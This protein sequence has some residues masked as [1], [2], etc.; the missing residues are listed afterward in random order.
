[1]YVLGKRLQTGST[2]SISA[3]QQRRTDG[4]R[5][6]R[7]TTETG[8]CDYNGRSWK[9]RRNKKGG[10]IVAY[11]LTET[12]A[13]DYT[14]RSWMGRHNEK[15]ETAAAQQQ[16]SNSSTS[17]AAAAAAA[18]EEE[19]AAAAAVVAVAAQAA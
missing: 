7:E 13:C 9:G 5:H 1:M 11:F 3:L 17:A 18:A 14:G 10:K 6:T 4:R 12:G 19:E 16:L 15:G 8:A 2:H